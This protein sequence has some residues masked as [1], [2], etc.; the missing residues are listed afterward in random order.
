MISR[1][2]PQIDTRSASVVTEQLVQWLH[3]YAPDWK[4][5]DEATGAP[6]GVSAGLIGASG[7]F[8]DVLIQRLNQVPQKNF[9]A[10]LDLQGAALLPPQPARVPLTFVPAKGSLV[11]ALVPPGTQVA[12]APGP[13]EKEPV[14]YETKDNLVVT[15]AQLQF[16]FARD[17]GQDTYADYSDD[18]IATG[19]TATSIFRGNRSI[20]HVLYLGQSGLLDSERMTKFSVLVDLQ[21]PASQGDDID[22]KWELWDGIQWRDITPQDPAKDGTKRLSQSGTIDFGK[23]PV[24]GIVAVQG[25][26]KEWVRCRLLTPITPETTA[27]VGMARAVGL[28]EIRSIGTRVHLQS[29]RLLFDQAYASASGDIDLSKDFYPFGEKPKFGDTF[30]LGL[31]EDFGRG[32]AKVAI[33]VNVTSAPVS[34]GTPAPTPPPAVPSDDIRLRWEAWTGKAWVE[35]GTSTKTGV[36]SATV[37]GNAFSESTKALSQKGEIGFTLP[38]QA[39]SFSLNGKT[40]YWIRVRIASGNYGVEGHFV[41]DQESITRFKFVPAN[42]T[43]PSIKE[44]FA[45]Y[46]VDRPLPPATQAFPEAVITEN[47]FIFEDRTAE[48]ADPDKSFAPFA[49]SQEPR[50]TLYL[51]FLL[52]PA[53]SFPNRPITMFFDSAHLRYGERTAPL[54]P[55]ES[56]ASANADDTA[57][58]RFTLTNDSSREAAYSVDA[59]GSQWKP[60]IKSVNPDGSLGAALS[61]ISLTSGGKTDL[62][63]QVTVPADAAIGATDSGIVR[64]VSAAGSLST[65]EFVTTA[66]IDAADSQQPQLTWE[67]RTKQEWAG[68]TVRDDTANLTTSGAVEFLAPADFALHSEMGVEAWWIR[69]RWD[70]GD[71]DMLPR[72]ARVL[73]NTTMAEQTVT[74]RNENLGSSDGSAGQRFVLTRAPVLT[75]QRLMVR[76]PEMPTGDDLA[77]IVQDEGAQAIMTIPGGAGKADEIWVTWHEVTD[78]YASQRRSRHYVFDHIAGVVSFGDG[79]SGMIPPTGTANIRPTGTANIRLSVF[80]TGGGVRG[81]KPAGS[82][83]QLKTTIPY[84]DKVTNHL[85]A[86]GGADAESTDS[87]IARAPTEIRHRRRAVTKEDYEDIAR[88]ASPDVARALC[89]P[90]RDLT[91]AGSDKSAP[92][93]VSVIIVPNATDPRPQPS[94]ELARRVQKFMSASCPVTATVIVVGAP[95]LRVD[96]QTEIGLRSLEDAATVTSKVQDALT[97]FLHPLTGGADGNGWEF[98]REPHRSD[99]YGMIEKIPEVGHISALKLDSIEDFPGARETGRFLVYSGT[100]SIALKYVP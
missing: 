95:Y 14:I 71:F 6:K 85:E 63:V 86:T 57:D 12:A 68:L 13:G 25:T 41:P 39:A 76:E 49:A 56:Q 50:P 62:N 40:D 82:I 11:D 77:T 28:P 2:P 94:L 45:G 89:V 4:D 27:R 88:L 70:A 5:F 97:Q 51:G 100:H 66:S 35:L 83:V 37:N 46:D 53:R 64:L 3:K 81:N 22:V 78:F 1:P 61:S 52:P 23:V 55:D 33:S 42:F 19:S 60:V 98:G 80:K 30:W 59:I 99:I 32:G 38:P 75:G 43:P 84:L 29:K 92:G 7:R 87:L 21:A 69:V 93:K 20:A 17:P 73:L 36:E 31:P 90:N 96:V 47:D 74:I 15:A 72:L 79:R 9:F 54:F 48:N 34:P 58:H 24:A 8:A 10:F 91:D 44:L 65:A 67:Y 18:L 16:A 26:A